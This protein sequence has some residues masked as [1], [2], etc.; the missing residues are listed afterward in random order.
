[1][2]Q[3]S[4]R[5]IRNSGA[6]DFEPRHI[7][8]AAWA[9]AR[10]QRHCRLLGWPQELKPYVCRPALRILMAEACCRLDH[11]AARELS[12]LVWAVSSQSCLRLRETGKPLLEYVQRRDRAPSFD[13][14]DL[15]SLV[16]SLAWMLERL[17]W[18]VPG[19]R[20]R[21][22]LPQQPPRRPPLRPPAPRRES[23]ATLAGASMCSV[24]ALG[25][26]ASGLRDVGGV[27]AEE[28]S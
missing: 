20:T 23:G 4:A 7:M 1:M 22:K 16:T 27:Q 11:F 6:K 3:H 10:W 13:A 15:V 24:R 26:M 8:N 25:G 12:R 21:S 18:E 14:D 17:V 5:E 2:L 28:K 19:R 9:L